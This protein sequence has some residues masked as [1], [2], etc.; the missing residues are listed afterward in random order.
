MIDTNVFDGTKK[1]AK[2]TPKEL[3]DLLAF[4]ITENDLFNV[5]EAGMAVVNG[6]FIAIGGAGTSVITVEANEKK[7]SVSYRDASAYLRAYRS[8]PAK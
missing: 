4:V 1:D 5:T 6:Q 3:D 2:L 8:R 7:H